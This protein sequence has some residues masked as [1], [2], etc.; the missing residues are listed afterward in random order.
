M[1]DLEKSRI[2][3]D[4]QRTAASRATASSASSE[5]IIRHLGV[6]MYKERRR[7]ERSAGKPEDHEGP[8]EQET[9]EST[10]R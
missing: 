1:S 2:Q 10:V 8:G 7:T 4:A 3:R 5:A 9:K 6:E